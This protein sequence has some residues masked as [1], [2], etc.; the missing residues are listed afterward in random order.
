MLAEERDAQQGGF[1]A[2]LFHFKAFGADVQL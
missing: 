1:R 2:A